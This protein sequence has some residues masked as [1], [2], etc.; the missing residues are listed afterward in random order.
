MQNLTQLQHFKLVAQERSFARAAELANISQPA[1]SNSI[2]SLET[3]LGMTLIERSER[4]VRLTSA[5]RNIYDRVEAVLFEARNLDQT[6]ANLGTGQTGHIRV[7][8]TAVYSTSLAG[9]IIAEWHDAHPNV[10]LD[11]IVD[12]TTHL[13]AGL[14]DE[15]YDLIV[16]DAR[17]LHSD[18]DDLDLTQLPPQTSGAF[19]RSGHPVLKIVKPRV[20]DLLRYKLAGTHF[21]KDLLREFASALGVEFA[22]SPPLIAINS[23]N[24]AA[25]R[26]AVLDSDLVLMTT[27]G[28]VRNQ[29]ALGLFEQVP[30]DLGISGKWMIATMRNR[31]PHPSVPKLHNKILEVSRREY[32][33]RLPSPPGIFASHS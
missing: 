31:V 6:I 22:N 3:R 8:M 23:T 5:G 10:R 9:P 19:C 12:E 1:L 26:D 27:T 2:R 14:R 29:L 25:L 17:D 30:I 20:S 11:L 18:V 32:E 13:V 28:T 16:G 21:P 33:R 4:P 15:T 24:I 7:G